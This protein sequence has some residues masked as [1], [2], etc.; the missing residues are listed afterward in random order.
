MQNKRDDKEVASG[1]RCYAVTGAAG[2]VGGRLVSCL[3]DAGYSVVAVVRDQ[4]SGEALKSRGADVRIADV[5]LPEQ[6]EKAFK[7]V[8]GVFHVA[9][10]FNHPDHSWDDYRDVNVTGAVNVLRAAQK[11][12]VEKVV[13]TSTIGVATEAKPPPYDEETPYSPQPDDKYEVSKA[14]GEIAVREFAEENNLRLTVI[15]PAQVYG[16]GDRSKAKFYKLVKKGVIVSPGNTQKHLVYVDDL[17]DAFLKAM[18]SVAADGEVFVIAG[19]QPTK[20]TQLVEL[21][22]AEL[23]VPPPR[24]KLPAKP[25]VIACTVVEKICNGLRVKPIIFRRSM[26]FFTRT[27]VCDT[28]KAKRVLGFECQ[29][30]VPDGVRQTVSW[31]RLQEL[32]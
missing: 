11:A 3:L 28:T 4:R 18:R 10:L 17:C 16:P 32:I 21:A 30:A 9:A 27:V 26:D 31:L 25:V 13:H 1:Q 12:G 8:D 29:T 19:T 6:L 20:L 22:A 2:F 14:E 5:R 7:G 24:V 23:G 15:R